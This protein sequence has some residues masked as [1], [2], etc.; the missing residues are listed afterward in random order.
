MLNTDYWAA[1]YRDGII[2]FGNSLEGG[3]VARLEWRHF[4]Y[5]NLSREDDFRHSQVGI[6]HARMELVQEII[7]ISCGTYLT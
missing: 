6:R 2:L 7:G 5:T 3:D 1:K 4:L